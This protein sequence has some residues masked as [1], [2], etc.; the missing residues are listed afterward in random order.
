MYV[1]IYIYVCVMGSEGGCLGWVCYQSKISTQS[2]GIKFYYV[3]NIYVYIVL[4]HM[5]I[6]IK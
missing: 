5:F 2:D 1:Y 3:Y 4:I 6:H